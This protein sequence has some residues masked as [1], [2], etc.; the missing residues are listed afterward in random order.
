MYIICIL[1]NVYIMITL[2]FYSWYLL[3]FQQ[4]RDDKNSSNNQ[5]EQ[6]WNGI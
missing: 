3:T 4:R 1:Y 6:L 2:I 5:P